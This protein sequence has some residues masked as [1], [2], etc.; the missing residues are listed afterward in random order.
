[1]QES[2]L[3]FPDKYTFPLFLHIRGEPLGHIC[4]ILAENHL[5]FRSPLVLSDH[6][7]WP[8]AGENV[9]LELKDHHP[10]TRYA[11]VESTDLEETQSLRRLI[12]D[13]RI[14]LVVGVGGGRVIDT[15]KYCSWER[16]V[17]FVS[18]PTAAANDGIASP[19][20]VMQVEGKQ[21]SITTAM[22]MGV[23]VDLQVIRSAPRQRVIAGI[24]DLISNLSSV[25]DWE[26]AQQRGKER[27]DGFAKTLSLM[28]GEALLN[29]PS[30]DLQ[31]LTFLESLVSGLVLSGIAMGVVG[32]SRPASGAEHEFSHALNQVLD[33]PRVHGE[34]VALGTLLVSFLRGKDFKRIHDFFSAVGAPIT[35]SALGIPDEKIIEALVLAPDIRPERYTLFNEIRPSAA[36]AR[37]V[38]RKAGV[39]G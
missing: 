38:A 27:V 11:F 21:A 39:I 13:E 24:C 14:D 8:I 18:F 37:D 5:L 1:M 29:F 6:D 35:A 25:E 33:E 3:Y 19:I 22:P 34:Q 20:A 32:S 15:G 28:A 12:Q 4:E 30:I 16:R 2:W 10:A 31:D 36:D 23:I 26:L 17:N 9:F 7:V